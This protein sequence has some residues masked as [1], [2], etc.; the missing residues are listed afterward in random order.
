MRTPSG[1]TAVTMATYTMKFSMARFH[2]KKRSENFVKVAWFSLSK[3]PLSFWASVTVAS[4]EIK[5]KQAG[6]RKVTLPVLTPSGEF[7]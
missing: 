1:A 7:G 6:K 2:I 4:L 5:V 3:W